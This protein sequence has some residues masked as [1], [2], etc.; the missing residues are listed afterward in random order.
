VTRLRRLWR[1]FTRD[2]GVY[3]CTFAGVLCAQYVPA[4]LKGQGITSAFQV[5]RLVGS[6]ALTLFIVASSES[7]GDQIAK[8]AHTRRRL[9]AAFTH[10]YTWNGLIGVAGQAL[11]E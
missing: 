4:L 1:Q 11:R 9:A 6:L 3:I 5:F 10:G 8:Q 2:L 7:S